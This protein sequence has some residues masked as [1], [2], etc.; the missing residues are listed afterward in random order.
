MTGRVSM[1]GGVSDNTP[2]PRPRTS[3]HAARSADR[4]RLRGRRLRGALRGLFRW[5]LKAAEK[6]PRRRRRRRTA[7]WAQ[8]RGGGAWG[9]AGIA[10]TGQAVHCKGNETWLNLMQKKKMRSQ[11][12]HCI[13]HYS[14]Q[15]IP[16]REE[17]SL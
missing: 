4:G 1:A 5:P 11:Y 17:S 10:T 2:A 9:E 14:V 3:H 7:G 13:S 6:S 16:F 8:G 12:K 15:R